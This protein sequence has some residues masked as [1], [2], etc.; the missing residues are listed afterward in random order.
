MSTSRYLSLATF[1]QDGAAVATPVWV[2]R[3]G[4]SL[5]VATDGTSCNI[6][7]LRHSGQVLA[8]PC[9]APAMLKGEHMSAHAQ[10]Y[11]DGG[12]RSVE[13][14]GKCYGWQHKIFEL[15]VKPRRQK[16]E[17]VSVEISL[18]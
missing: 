1:K 15:V 16:T 12:T 18:A 11:D 4:N 3:D 5:W 13:L 9:D 10:V 17:F 8:A 7:R 14:I 2:A 6:M